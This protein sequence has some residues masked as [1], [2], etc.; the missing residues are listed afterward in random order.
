MF[1]PH[2]YPR[3]TINGNMT[4]FGLA[5]RM[6]LNG[7]AKAG[8]NILRFEQRF[9]E[10]IGTPYAVGVESARKGLYLILKSRGFDPGDEVILPDY[11]FQALPV[12]VMACGLKPVFVDVDPLT[13]NINPALIEEAVTERTKAIVV[14]HMF[15]HPVDMDAVLRVARKHR[16]FVVE[17]CA[18]GCGGK[19]RNRRLGSL[20]DAAIFSF[21]MGKNLPCFGGGMIA[22]RDARLSANLKDRVMSFSYPKTSDLVRDIAGTFLFYC[23]THRNVFPWL[24]YPI[25]RVLDSVGSSFSDDQIE[26][27]LDPAQSVKSLQQQTRL[28]NLQAA[29][30]LEQLPGLDNFNDK[31]RV[32]AR[33]LIE[34]LRNVRNISLPAEDPES[35]PT[36]LYFRLQVPETRSIRKTLLSRGVDTK[37]DD[38]SACSTLKNFS[39]Y[40]RHCPNAAELSLRSIEIPNNPF[41]NE[42]DISYIAGQIIAAVGQKGQS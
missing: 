37:R 12:V 21:K 10:Y 2:A 6:I 35:L 36:Y 1:V 28:T 5:C 18:H 33:R 38:M 4:L 41:L 26:E 32:N 25:L 27:S 42:K 7:T 9:A 23:S 29:V 34:K 8:E 20:G 22:T 17:D 15:G 19:Y 30:G 24:M 40:R 11:T 16:L 13:Y 39:E 3:H 31:L 14:T